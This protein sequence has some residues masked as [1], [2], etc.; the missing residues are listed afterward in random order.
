MSYLKPILVPLAITA[1]CACTFGA[2]SIG[3][4]SAL[5][6]WPWTSVGTDW[7]QDMQSVYRDLL[8]VSYHA[9]GNIKPIL[10]GEFAIIIGNHPSTFGNSQLCYFLNNFIT[11]KYSTV[12]KDDLEW[13]IRAPLNALKLSV[14][15]NRYDRESARL[16]VARAIPDLAERGGAL[17]LFVDGTR[18]GEKKR[19]EAR[20]KWNRLIHDFDNWTTLPPRSG[21]LLTILQSLTKPTRIFN[22]TQ[23]F[24]VSDENWLDVH[25][26]FGAR[27]HI[28]CEEFSSEELPWDS[29]GLQA[30]LVREWRRK[31]ELIA[32]WREL[33]R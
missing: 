33:K 31:N 2:S 22:F 13:I 30:W 17:L 12:I 21:A 14:P 24:S 18:P 28:E 5:T 26:L 23:S 7:G 15:I 32:K 29:M 20:K 4:L 9:E 8:H 25:R 1:G 10:P 6:P 27:Y 16:A 11:K 3:A 19:K